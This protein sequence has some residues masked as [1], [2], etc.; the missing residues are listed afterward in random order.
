MARYNLVNT[1]PNGGGSVSPTFTADTLAH[2]QAV[3]QAWATLFQ[4]SCLLAVLDTYPPY[5][6]Y[7]PAA[8]GSALGNSPTG[9]GN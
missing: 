2:A 6:Q 8:A 7:D 3:A 5:T 1:Y 9:I 4:K